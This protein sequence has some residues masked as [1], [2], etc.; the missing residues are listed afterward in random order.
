MKPRIEDIDIQENL[1]KNLVH[2][3]QLM[4]KSHVTEVD[5]ARPNKEIQQLAFAL[6][7]RGILT[8]L[9]AIETHIE[10]LPD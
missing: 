1:C 10:A 7:K 4:Q 9:D 8:L 3:A 5:P 2:Y 6:R